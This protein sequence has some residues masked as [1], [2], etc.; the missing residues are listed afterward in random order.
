MPRTQEYL[1]RK[2]VMTG[3]SNEEEEDTEI[4]RALPFLLEDKLKER[5][6]VYMS[7][8]KYRPHVKVCERV[9]TGQNPASAKPTA[10]TIV[11]VLK[12]AVL[13]E[14]NIEL[15]KSPNHDFNW[16]TQ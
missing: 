6:S 8:Y 1:I 12:C 14:I 2:K 7:G 3:I 9:V 11:D 13:K 16:V 10:E 15:Q 5:E 4:A